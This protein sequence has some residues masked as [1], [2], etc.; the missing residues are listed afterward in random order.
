MID[1]YP[2]FSTVG[3]IDSEPYYRIYSAFIRVVTG[4]SFNGYLALNFIVWYLILYAGLK[5]IFKPD[6]VTVFLLLGF[7]SITPA[8]FYYLIRSG[9]PYV[10]VVLVFVLYVKK[11]PF[12]ALALS[13]IAVGFHSQYIPAI[14]VLAIGYFWYEHIVKKQLTI[15]NN[16]LYISVL[17]FML[18]IVFKWAVPIL[19]MM[20]FLPTDISFL[21]GKARALTG[22]TE[23][24]RLTSVLSTVVFPLIYF[25][26]LKKEK[27]LKVFQKG[28]SRETYNRFIF[29]LGSIILLSFIVN[30]VFFNTP[31]VAAR[32]SRFGDYTFMMIGVGTF[33]LTMKNSDKL[34]PLILVFLA[35]IA[36]L[37]YPAVYQ[38]QIAIIDIW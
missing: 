20:S 11:R 28:E 34:L 2:Y 35:A 19:S 15:S 17:S 18:M 29:L 3:R 14:F 5:S 7:L 25:Y 38:F 31:L 22:G 37:L 12:W 16:L 21:E 23:G 10:L 30:L 36:P 26:L 24:Y 27:F 13:F 1:T 8:I 33:L 6:V 9:T 4:L 32:L